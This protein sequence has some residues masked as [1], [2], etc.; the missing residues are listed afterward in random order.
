MFMH[1][2]L[3]VCRLVIIVY[4]FSVGMWGSKWDLSVQF[5]ASIYMRVQLDKNL[6][7]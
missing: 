2:T 7:N 1:M 5:W 3:Q 4:I 6:T